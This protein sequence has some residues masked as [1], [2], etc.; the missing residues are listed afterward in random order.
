MSTDEQGRTVV[1][2]DKY[3]YGISVPSGKLLWTK[4]LWGG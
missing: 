3:V 1:D 4:T 2:D